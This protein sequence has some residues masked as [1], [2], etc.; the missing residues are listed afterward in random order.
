MT[1]VHSKY[2]KVIESEIQRCVEQLDYVLK[3]KGPKAAQDLVESLQERLKEEGVTPPN[4]VSTPYINTI[5]PE[6]QPDYPGEEEI[7]RK[8]RSMVRWNA[9]A[10]VVKANRDSD[11]IG[12]HIST[13]ASLATLMEVGMN[14]IF[15]GNNGSFEADQVFFQGH[16]SPGNYARS[17]LEGRLDEGRLHNFRQEL[18]KENGLSSYPHPYLMPDYWQFPTVSMGLGPIM[19]IYQARFNRYLRARKIIKTDRESQV[20]CFI[21]DGEAG[22]PETFGCLNMAVR[23]KLDNLTFIVNCNLQRLDGPVNGNGKIIQEFEGIF[24]GAGWNVIKVIWGTDWD[25]FL[26]SEHRDLLIKRMGEVIDG[27]YQKYVV[28]PGSYI[29]KHFFGKYPALLEL[30]NHKTDAQ[31]TKL[32]RGG[33]DPR[34]VY[35][36]Y[37]AAL[38]HKGSPSVILAKTVKGY[39][40]GEAG[41]GKNISHQQKKMNEKELREFRE[42]FEIPISDEDIVE[43]PFFRPE[44]DS[45]EMKY[46]LER[47]KELGGFLPERK[48]TTETLVVPQR[49]TFNEFLK[50]S[51]EN[52][53]STTMAFVRILMKLLRDKNIGE[54]LVPI[55]PDEAR[56][57]G[58]EPLFRQ[59]G[60]YNPNGQNYEPVDR[61]SLLYYK[62]ATDGQVLEEG[63]N[64]AGAMSSFICSAT[65]YATHGVNTIPFY[66]YYS[67]F[68]F[69]RVGDLMWL[70][71]DM[72]AKGFLI[73]GTAGR[74]TLNGEGLQHQDGHGHLLANSIPN[75]LTYDPAFRYEIAVIIEDGLKR[76]Y[77][78]NE[79]VFYYLTV[80]NENYKMPEMPEGAEEG[81]RRG[82]YKFETSEMKANHKIQLIGSGSIVWSI[83][84]AKEI[85]EKNY[86]CSVDLW[87]ATSY[88]Q[89]RTEALNAERWNRLNPTEKPK[90][91]YLET[92]IQDEKGHFIAASDNVKLIPDQI[93]K[94]V[95]GGLLTLGT[96]G[97]GRSASR[98]DLRRFFEVDAEMIVIATLYKLSQRGEIKPKVVEDAISDLKVD[99]DKT[100]PMLK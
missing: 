63:I 78:E 9:M 54:R 28:S 14:H 65:S 39:G 16:A 76:M 5:R 69:Q 79:N 21:G 23:E 90:K 82:L 99:K 8:I 60:I 41:E 58:M 96:D 52:E 42:R 24:K 64:E 34:K 17:Y 32:L 87:S 80:G 27:E 6:E 81:I 73:G 88:K 62:E 95:P 33:H 77:E 43:T 53:M 45:N 51:G 67:M 48:Q 84:K 49:E 22:E 83:I 7:E 46:L 68:G 74:T 61:E 91:S 11:G 72:R 57:F 97:F 50:D 66:I 92:I 44:K 93:S 85:L 38:N 29:R 4:V 20:Y 15:H 26:N 35:A 1:E 36:A 59:I 31:L 100:F 25:E 12:G 56:T 55:I 86:S 94:W 40:L 89:L 10:M 13:Y 3:Y 30:V 70:A 37:Q 2:S 18:R 75:L 98:E 71:G 47:R 19:A